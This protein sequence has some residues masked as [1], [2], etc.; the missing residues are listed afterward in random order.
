VAASARSARPAASRRPEPYSL[1]R[2]EGRN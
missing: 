1:E 2:P